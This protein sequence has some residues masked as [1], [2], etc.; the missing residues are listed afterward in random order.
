MGPLFEN[1]AVIILAAGLGTR[2]KSQKA[3]VLHQV[4][5]QPMILYVVDTAVQVAGKDIILVVGHQV[6]QV[7]KVVSE[8]AL[9]EYA[10]QERQ[11][12]TGHAVLCALP[13][14]PA[15]SEHIVILCGDVPMITADTIRNL[16]EDHLDRERDITVLAVEI[17]KPAGYGRVLINV[18]NQ[19]TGIVEEADAT[20]EEKKIRM[21]NTGIYC[22]EKTFL[23]ESL[24]KIDTDNAQGELYL[25]DIIAVGHRE[26]KAVGALLAGDEHEFYGINSKEDLEIVEGLMQ[27]RRSG[28]T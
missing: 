24:Q 11:L 26:K 19:V 16:V 21:I 25:T 6:E 2:M 27:R 18:D 12:G 13:Q 20:N 5:G 7:R 8:H 17:D 23:A 3:K 15:H 28:S 9:A 1:I 22:V 4:L 14:V 10:Y